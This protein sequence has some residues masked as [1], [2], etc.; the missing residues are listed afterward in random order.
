M[1]GLCRISAAS[2]PQPPSARRLSK[3]RTATIAE[4]AAQAVE[5]S[6]AATSYS[7]IARGGSTAAQRVS[8]TSGSTL[9]R[10][11]TT[12][13][14]GLK[15]SRGGNKKGMANVSAVASRAAAALGAPGWGTGAGGANIM[16]KYNMGDQDPHAQVRVLCFEMCTLLSPF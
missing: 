2:S 10:S 3:A 6:R 8:A 4:L 13:G 9:G 7:S 1:V 16:D 14:H 12:S 15:F 5:S 11:T